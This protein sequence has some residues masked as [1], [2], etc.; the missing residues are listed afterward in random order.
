MRI[1]GMRSRRAATV[2][3]DVALMCGL[4]PTERPACPRESCADSPDRIADIPVPCGRIG[5]MTSPDTAAGRT[6]PADITAAVE[7][8]FAGCAD[9]RLRDIMQALVRHLH[10]FVTDV[11]LTEDE[12]RTAI[13][14]LTATGHITDDHRQEF[15]LW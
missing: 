3:P 2:T 15:I 6:T 7:A 5:A 8:R 11:E 1:G 13:A 10:A 12:W 14:T 9:P 4:L